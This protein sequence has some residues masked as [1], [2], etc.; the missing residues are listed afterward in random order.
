MSQIGFAVILTEEKGALFYERI[1]T[2]MLEA[3]CEAIEIHTP[4]YHEMKPD[5]ELIKIIRQFTYRSIHT[6]GLI[7]E[8][9]CTDKLRYYTELAEKIDTHAFTVHPNI[10][11]EWS[12]LVKYFGD[13]LSYENMDWRKPFAT[14]PSHM[15]EVFSQAPNARWTYD[16]NHVYTVD[17]SMKL[18]DEFYDSFSNLGHYHISG[19]KDADLPHTTLYTTHQDIIAEYVRTDHPII[20]ESFGIYDIQDFQLELD[21]TKKLL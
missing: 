7:A 18:A 21:Y 10:M 3:G 11:D 8:D 4:D 14:L 15:K 6:R 5:S 19:F 16:L 1:L 20:I 2:D 9:K 12:W 13:L 17:P